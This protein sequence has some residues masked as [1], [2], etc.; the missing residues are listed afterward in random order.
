M[1]NN[2]NNYYKYKFKTDKMIRLNSNE[3]SSP[4]KQDSKTGIK[5]QTNMGAIC[6]MNDITQ[7]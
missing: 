7:F 5:K 4:S 6:A 3:S 2:V 1:L